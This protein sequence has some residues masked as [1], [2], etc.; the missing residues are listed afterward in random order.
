VFEPELGVAALDSELSISVW[1]LRPA[2]GSTANPEVDVS[3]LPDVHMVGVGAIGNGAI[4]ALSRLSC[5]GRLHVIDPETVTDSNLKRYVMLMADDRGEEKVELA[6]KWLKPNAKLKVESHVSA[7]AE[8]VSLV[9][10]HKVDTVLSAVDTA[11][12][13][14]EIQ[15]S[16]PRRIFNA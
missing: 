16:L 11:K 12:T 13:R 10:D 1:D 5:R 2:G 3:H 4:W 15:A 14:I 8:H 7:W 9:S 6:R